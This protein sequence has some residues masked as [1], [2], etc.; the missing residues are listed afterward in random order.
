MRARSSITFAIIASVALIMACS[1]SPAT[2]P[3]IG[4]QAPDFTLETI[5]GESLSLSDFRGNTVLIVFRAVYCKG[6]D[7]QMP[8]ILSA[9]ERSPETLTVLDIY[10]QD[11]A[12]RV[13]KHVQDKQLTTF[14]ALPDP[15]DTVGSKKYQLPLATPI[16]V[17]VDANGIIKAIKP[18]P[19]Q[20]QEDIE[21][22][23]DSSL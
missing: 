10:R 19:F 18:G 12:R 7:E 15:D 22:W 21:D 1:G 9:Y 8:Y 6:C 11:P 3:E 16:N 23:L 4:A 17:L 2:C 20:S 5:D 13:R 14:P